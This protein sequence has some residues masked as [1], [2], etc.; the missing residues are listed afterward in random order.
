MERAFF[1]K[2]LFLLFIL[3]VT[4][5]SAGC[6]QSEE[7]EN[8]DAYTLVIDQLYQEDIALNSDIKYIAL[9]TSLILNLNHSEKQELFQELES[10]GLIVL[11]MTIEELEEEGYIKNLFFEEG[12][13]FEI[14]DRP[15]QGNIITMDVSKWRSG[16]GAIGYD[17]LILKYKNG[18]WKIV[19]N[20]NAWI[21]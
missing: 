6:S 11:D 8:V 15:I 21:S 9:D 2:K 1:T 4:L 5:F 7:I 13:L 18:K 10:Y 3:S 20:G 14:E 12:I 17:G 16:L 19:K